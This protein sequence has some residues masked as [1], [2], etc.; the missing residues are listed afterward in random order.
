MKY[1]LE[2]AAATR[3]EFWMLRSDQNLNDDLAHAKRHNRLEI[4]VD[5]PAGISNDRFIVKLL[6]ADSF[7]SDDL[8][9]FPFPSIRPEIPQG[10][11]LET[12]KSHSCWDGDLWSSSSAFAVKCSVRNILLMKADR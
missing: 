2:L 5:A 7:Y 12:R 1:L 8:I 11:C 10:S 9:C 3:P 6:E 4:V